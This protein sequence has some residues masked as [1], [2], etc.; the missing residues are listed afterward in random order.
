MIVLF[1]LTSATKNVFS[2]AW[3]QRI[4][5]KEQKYCIN[6]Y[7]FEQRSV[8]ISTS[9][10]CTVIR[11]LLLTVFGCTQ[12][13]CRLEFIYSKRRYILDVFVT[14]ASLAWDSMK[15]SGVP[16]KSVNGKLFAEVF[17]VAHVDKYNLKVST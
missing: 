9:L 10:I 3:S 6:Q 16:I 11:Y 12:P 7:S 15:E 4:K 17:R 5:P 13:H 2:P 8:F 14:R 1:A